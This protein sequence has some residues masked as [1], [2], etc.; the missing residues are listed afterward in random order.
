MTPSTTLPPRSALRQHPAPHYS[1]EWMLWYSPPESA[2]T[3]PKFAPP[4]VTISR[5]W[6]CNSTRERT[7]NHPWTTTWMSYLC[8]GFD[9]TRPGDSRTGRLDDR[10]GVLESR[11][12][13]PV[14]SFAIA[15]AC[16]SRHAECNRWHRSAE[17]HQRK[18]LRP[19]PLSR[20][21]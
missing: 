8:A 14:S 2:K 12:K 7:R 9:R 18:F 15:L 13:D 4:C 21:R 5:S 1:A 3:H 19:S 16:S 11:E 20:S 6:A 10:A 17:D